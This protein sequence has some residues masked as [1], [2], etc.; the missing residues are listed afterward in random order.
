V[1]HTKIFDKTGQR[2]VEIQENGKT[3]WTEEHTIRRDKI[4]KESR[5]QLVKDIQNGDLEAYARKTF[6]ILTGQTIEQARDQIE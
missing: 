5:K 4:S 6:E 1:T 3:V 2:V